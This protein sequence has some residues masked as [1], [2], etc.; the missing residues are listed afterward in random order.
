MNKIT[1]EFPFQLF[2]IGRY[3][4]I[5]INGIPIGSVRNGSRHQLELPLSNVAIE[6]R[7]KIYR[8]EPVFLQLADKPAT[9]LRVGTF[10]S[11]VEA[12]L[13]L[14]ILGALC[15]FRHSINP[16][17]LTA[18]VIYMTYALYF[19][20]FNPKRFLFLKKVR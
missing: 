17:L 12:V 16:Y 10:H 5:F 11:N 4:D 8:T 1:I 18:A 2:H 13:A 15:W 6:A 20:V 19:A 14:G 7:F 3:V 9:E